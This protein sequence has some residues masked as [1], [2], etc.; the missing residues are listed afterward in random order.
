MK[1]PNRSCPAPI[2]PL[3]SSKAN[4]VQKINELTH[5][6]GGGTVISEGLAW[7]WRA[8][9]PG[10]PFSQGVAY[11]NTDVKKIIILL[12][13][14]ANAVQKRGETDDGMPVDQDVYGDYTAYGYAASFNVGDR[15]RE[16]FDHSDNPGTA[17]FDQVRDYLDT[18]TRLVCDNIKNADDRHP[19]EI[20]S[21]LV[22]D[23]DSRTEELLSSCATSE[24]THYRNAAQMDELKEAFGEVATEIIG[25]GRARIVH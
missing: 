15:R 22:G 14:G 10:E 16:L 12:S 13:D 2:L 21:V 20:F 9:S 24:V 17:Y 18:R 6:N 19:V 11:D 1:G 5:R 3:T 7:G 23:H 25:S 8:I 4:V